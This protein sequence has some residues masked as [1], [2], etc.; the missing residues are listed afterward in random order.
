MYSR[1]SEY[2]NKIQSGLDDLV[3]Y[4]ETL[5]QENTELQQ[6]LK[7]ANKIIDDLESQKEV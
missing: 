3:E 4:A 2:A 1:I 7:D 5:E 6:E